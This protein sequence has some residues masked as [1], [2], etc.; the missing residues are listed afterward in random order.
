M[1]QNERR[2][3]CEG[4]YLGAERG[5]AMMVGTAVVSSCIGAALAIAIA[6]ALKKANVGVSVDN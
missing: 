6:H 5:T 3:L 1:K 4:V 2:R